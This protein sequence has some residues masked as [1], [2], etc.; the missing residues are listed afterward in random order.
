MKF[1]K[2][3]KINLGRKHTEET[4]KK[5]SISHKGKPQNWVHNG[6]L[7]KK[8]SEEWKKKMSEMMKGKKRK[9]MSLQ[10][11]INIGLAHKGQIPW[12][13][14]LKNVQSFES[15]TGENNKRWKGDKVSYR[16]LHKWLEKK[17]GKP[18]KCQFC[19]TRNAKV[20]DWANISKEYKRE[21][22]DWIRLCRSCH[23]KY[24]KGWR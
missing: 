9:P 18:K 3:H 21:K 2:G 10:G 16:E 12:N 17:L 11:R 19:N 7:G 22:S 24:D 1:Q 20:Y 8:H 5:L 15:T 4:K 23:I 6:M 14:G 13:K